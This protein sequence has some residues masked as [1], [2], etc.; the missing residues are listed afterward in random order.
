[1]ALPKISNKLTVAPTAVPSVQIVKDNP[2]SRVALQGLQSLDARVAQLNRMVISQGQKQ[3]ETMGL[4]YGAANAVTEEQIKLAQ[5]TG[6][7]VT[8]A[9]LVG[10]DTSINIFQ[11]A[12]RKGR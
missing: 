3:A 6:Q 1:M 5:E 11:Q 7:P 9:D 2:Q 10:D 12:A 4:K 8:Q